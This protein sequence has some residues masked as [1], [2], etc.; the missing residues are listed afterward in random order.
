MRKP[1]YYKK[2]QSPETKMLDQVLEKFKDWK[3]TNEHY[4]QGE[5]SWNLEK[6]GFGLTIVV[7]E[8]EDETTE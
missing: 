6:E 4:S 1:N 8:L 2:F 5:M 7:Y 3:L